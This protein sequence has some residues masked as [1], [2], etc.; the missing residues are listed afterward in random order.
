MDHLQ[1]L[2][3]LAGMGVGEGVVAGDDRVV[4]LVE[5]G[6][7]GMPLSMVVIAWEQS[8]KE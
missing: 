1:L 7:A 8:L 2:V 5:V 6:G 4:E 3:A